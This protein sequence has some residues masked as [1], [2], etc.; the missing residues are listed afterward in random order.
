MKRRIQQSKADFVCGSPAVVEPH[1]VVEP[2]AVVECA[3]GA[4]ARNFSEGA[5]RATRESPDTSPFSVRASDFVGGVQDTREEFVG[6]DAGVHGLDIHRP[7]IPFPFS[8]K[9]LECLGIVRRLGRW[10]RFEREV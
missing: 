8:F 4:S 9:F 7:P 2:P 5:G 1:A 3:G 6:R 10:V